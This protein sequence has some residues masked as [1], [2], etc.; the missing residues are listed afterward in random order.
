MGEMN[1]RAAIML[2]LG[3]VI[4]LSQV[5]PMPDASQAGNCAPAV[6]AATCCGGPQTC[7]CIDKNDSPHKP[8]PVV[9]AA[10]DLN[11]S[12]PVPS[13]TDLVK[14]PVPT[15]TQADGSAVPGA[16]IRSGYA[17]VPL[18]VAFCSFVI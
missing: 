9:P 18:T 2:F 5:R 17:G 7:P 12:F 14:A 4:Q 8:A 10:S 6:T 1:I 16:G 11:F 15:P 13:G 3:L